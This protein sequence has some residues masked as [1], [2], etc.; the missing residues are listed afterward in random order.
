[1]ILVISEGE[2]SLDNINQD[3]VVMEWTPHLFGINVSKY[4]G[5]KIMQILIAFMDI[6]HVYKT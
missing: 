5:V 3:M 6:K 1:M 4:N 2:G